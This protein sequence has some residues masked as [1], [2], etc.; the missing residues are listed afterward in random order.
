MYLT[1][2]F[3]AHMKSWNDYREHIKAIDPDSSRDITDMVE[4]TEI[5]STVIKQ[6][7][8]LGLSQR[9]LAAIC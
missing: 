7:K 9:D 6:R 1:N 3:L 5:I 2:S 4:Q 8:E